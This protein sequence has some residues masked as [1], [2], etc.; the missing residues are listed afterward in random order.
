MTCEPLTAGSDLQESGGSSCG[1]W[2]FSAPRTA[3]GTRLKL[4]AATLGSFIHSPCAAVVHS[5][6]GFRLKTCCKRIRVGFTRPSHRTAALDCEEP[7]T[8]KRC[9]AGCL[10]VF[11]STDLCVEFL[12]TSTSWWSESL[13][14]GLNLWRSWSFFNYTDKIFVA[15]TFKVMSHSGNLREWGINWCVICHFL[16]KLLFMIDIGGCLP[17]EDHIFTPFLV[18]ATPICCTT[19]HMCEA[20]DKLLNRRCSTQH[21]TCNRSRSFCKHLCDRKVGNIAEK[22][23][24]KSKTW[25]LVWVPQGVEE[26]KKNIVWILCS[27]SFLNS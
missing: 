8:G 6:A 15:Y 13:Y 9:R 2:V 16:A 24:K 7:C 1:L 11:V 14:S 26:K 17:Y 3:P 20:A 25:E 22:V 23:V 18:S 4:Q 27:D 12:W 21:P 19:L 5:R 10:C